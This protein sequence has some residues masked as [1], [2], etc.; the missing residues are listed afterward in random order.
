VHVTE[1]DIDVLPR[2]TAGADVSSR[3]SSGQ[4]P[5]VAGLPD[6]TQRQLAQRY[7]EMF[8]VYV[9]HRDILDRVT[10]WGVRDGDSWLNGWPVRG[11]T[12]HPLLF[13]RA[14]Q[15]KPAFQ[16]VIDAAARARG[17]VP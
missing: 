3:S 10:F 12:N 15:T 13:D 2:P 7:G 14:G 9:K 16:A 5:F 11:R 6:S 8:T 4:N 17:V 1:L